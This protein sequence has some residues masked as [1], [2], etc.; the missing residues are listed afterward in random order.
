MPTDWTPA[1]THLRIADPRLAKVIEHHGPP[2][3]KPRKDPVQ[4]LARAIVSQQLSGAAAET[5]WGRFVALYPKG[6]F[7]AP[8]AILATEDTAL[9]AVGLSGAKAA[10]IKDLARHVIEAKVVPARLGKLT[11]EEVSAM[12]LPVRGIGPWSID[13]FLMFFLARPDVLPV[14]DLG[15]KKGM[16]RHFGLRKLPQADRMIKLAA[17]WRPFRTIASWYMWRLLET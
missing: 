11:D 13:M 16:Q 9:R 10:S 12:L 2:T 8:S 14:G 7:P 1:L 5:I 15:I 17:P 4:A 3:I 6:K